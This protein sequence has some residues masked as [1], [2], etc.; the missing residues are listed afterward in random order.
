GA[1]GAAGP[2]ASGR[3]GSRRARRPGRRTG[4]RLRGAA[5]ERLSR[6]RLLRHRR[7]GLLEGLGSLVLHAVLQRLVALV[8]E[9]LR[10]AEI[11]PLGLSLLDLGQQLLLQLARR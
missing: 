10:F 1:G 6:G 11:L 4:A 2:A 3:A 9:L 7:L 5:Q 8:V